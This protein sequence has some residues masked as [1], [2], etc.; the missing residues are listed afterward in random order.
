MEQKATVRA[1]VE[2]VGGED[3]EMSP[4]PY[5]FPPICVIQ[6]LDMPEFRLA[7]MGGPGKDAH[8][9]GTRAP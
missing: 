1:G 4:L 6:P 5:G 9:M 8:C 3:G 2:K 7:K